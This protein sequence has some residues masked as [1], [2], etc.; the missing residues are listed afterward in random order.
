MAEEI[1]LKKS[2]A[3]GKNVRQMRRNAILNSNTKLG[4][5]AAVVSPKTNVV[6]RSYMNPKYL[7]QAPEGL[8]SMIT[9]RAG[10]LGILGLIGSPSELG[11]GTI[12]DG[13]IEHLQ[14]LEAQMEAQ[15]EAERLAAAKMR[16]QSGYPR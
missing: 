7:T 16:L 10:P 8:L 1:E 5:Q 3:K 6:Q 4:N 14:A 11:D 2:N 15:R 12:P 9:K 13:Y